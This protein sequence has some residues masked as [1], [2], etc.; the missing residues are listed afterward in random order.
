[1]KRWTTQE[2]GSV[3]II[4]EDDTEI[5]A[6]EVSP[7]QAR[8][9]AAAPDMLQALQDI[10]AWMVNP[11]VNHESIAYFRSVAESAITRAGVRTGGH[12]E[13]GTR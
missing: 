9:I 13:T 4:C 5:V 6:S 11:D 2:V 12:D 3:Q 7:D 1:M 10:R 8:L